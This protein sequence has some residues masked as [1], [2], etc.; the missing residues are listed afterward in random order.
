MPLRVGVVGGSLGG[1]TAACLLRDAGHDV[2]IFERSSRELEQRGAGIGLLEAT[3]RY[4]AERIEID[5]DDI[6]IATPYIR[7]L[8]R[9]GEV[10]HEIGQPY[11][12]SS[13]N[14]VYR[15]LLDHWTT[16][17]VGTDRYR[18][19]HDMVDFEVQP[20]GPTSIV[21]GNGTSIDADLLVC[22]DGVGSMARRQLQPNADESYAGYVAWRGMVPEASLSTA[23]ATRLVDAITYYVFANSHI[24]VYPI[25]GLDGSVTPGERL[26]NFVWYR[27]YLA[28]AEFD[29]LVTDRHGG[30]REL[31]VPP[32]AAAQHHIDEVRATASARLPPPLAELVERTE[33]PF[34]QVVYDIEVDQMAFGNVCLLGDAAFAV[35]PHAAAGSA[36]AAE[37]A[38][39]LTAAL[40]AHDDVGA[41]LRAWERT[42][43]QLG[44]RLLQRTRQIG[45]RS[46]IDNSWIP[47][48]PE[49]IFGLHAPG[50]PRPEDLD[51]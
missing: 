18:L 6:S 37:D 43:L 16:D 36:K 34:V 49:F 19:G 3:A 21:F 39:T 2:T 5:L 30:R 15:C 12:F 26:V 48:D 32:G 35:R 8:D 24:L 44:Q 28:G 46:Q 13:W 40:G 51:R 9:R 20:D 47:G 45:R 10:T 14:T 33:E 7:H 42:Q 17:P 4:L 1:L 11:R 31:S 38:W 23:T 25:P 29:D 41:A 27:N 22:A 50:D